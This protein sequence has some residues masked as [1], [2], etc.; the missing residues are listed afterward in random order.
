[1]KEEVKYLM[2]E[3]AAEYCRTN[4]NTFKKW[5]KKHHIPYH[6]PGRR[7]LFLRVDLDRMLKGTRTTAA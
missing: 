4:I 1:M 2:I 5:I 7:Q 3:E 6:K